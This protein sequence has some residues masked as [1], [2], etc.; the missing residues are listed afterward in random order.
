MGLLHFLNRRLSSG[1][2]YMA[3]T[4]HLTVADLAIFVSVTVLRAT[5]VREGETRVATES[6]LDFARKLLNLP[7]CRNFAKC[8]VAGDAPATHP[9]NFVVVIALAH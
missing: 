5:R 2:G 7:I 4:D 1:T 6:T 3:L 8:A 9:V